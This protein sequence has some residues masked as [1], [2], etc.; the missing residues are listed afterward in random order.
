MFRTSAA[1]RRSP[2]VFKYPEKSTGLNPP[3]GNPLTQRR[4]H[5]DAILQQDQVWLLA[6][7]SSPAGIPATDRLKV[8]KQYHGPPRLSPSP[9]KSFVFRAIALA[10]GEASR[11]SGDPRYRIL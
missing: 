8:L 2:F 7:L 6:R 1:D 4:F 9:Q 3:L 10:T 5:R 11:I